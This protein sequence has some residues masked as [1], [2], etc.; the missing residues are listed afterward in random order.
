LRMLFVGG[1]QK[2][3]AEK[4]KCRG[5]KAKSTSSY[6]ASLSRIYYTC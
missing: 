5:A 2:R 1:A 4:P 3:C 6:P